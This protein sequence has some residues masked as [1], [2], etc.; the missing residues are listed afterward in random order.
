MSIF[1]VQINSQV[2]EIRNG[3]PYVVQVRRKQA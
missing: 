2:A 1:V 3:E